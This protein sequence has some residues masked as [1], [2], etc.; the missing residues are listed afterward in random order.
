GICLAR[1]EPADTHPRHRGLSF[2]VVDLHAPGVTVRPLRQ[3]TGEE[4]FSEVFLDAVF[5][6][7][8]RLVG[9][10]GAGWQVAATTLAH[11]RGTAFPVK[12]QAVHEEYLQRLLQATPDALRDPLARDEVAACYVALRLLA[13]ANL[14]TL[15]RLARGEAPGPESSWVKLCWS[16]MT[17][18]LSEL[19]LLL[20][21]TDPAI[22]RQYLWSRAATIAGGTSEI[23]RTI[24]AE[25]ILG[26]PRG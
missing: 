16:G 8:E 1:T 14:R 17:Q 20:R 5:V 13:I 25:R 10:R 6:P 4:E 9:P 12:E 2:L 21:P 19:G 24:I 11:E 26:L 18:R 22:T 3:L 7:A 15:S 23:Q